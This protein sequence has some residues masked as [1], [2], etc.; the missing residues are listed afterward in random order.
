[1][2]T[3]L[4]SETVH[5]SCIERAGR[6][7]LIAGPSGSGKSDLALRLIDR[8]ATL[9]SDDYTILTRVGQQLMAHAP[10]TIKGKIEVRDL[11][12]IEMKATQD[13]AVALIID[14]SEPSDRFPLELKERLIAGLRIPMMGLRPFEATAPIKAELALSQAIAL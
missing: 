7:L 8:G 3:A 4:T 1:M 2:I 12:I 9:I 14:L 13:V 11:G 5:A 10:E 6:A